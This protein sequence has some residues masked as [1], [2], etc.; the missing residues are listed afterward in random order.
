MSVLYAITAAFLEVGLVF[1][2]YVSSQAPGGNR[3]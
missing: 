2:I 3:G 1:V